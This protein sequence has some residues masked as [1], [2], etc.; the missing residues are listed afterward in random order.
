MFS[1]I[2]WIWNFLVHSFHQI[3]ICFSCAVVKLLKLINM[4]EKEIFTWR[5][6]SRNLNKNLVTDEIPLNCCLQIE[7][8]QSQDWQQNV[9][10]K[11]NMLL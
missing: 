5:H 8:K 10:E 11:R 1:D 7:S 3:A 6:V 4:L 2:E 9:T